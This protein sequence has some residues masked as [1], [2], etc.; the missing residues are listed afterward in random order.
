MFKFSGPQGRDWISSLVVF[1]VAL[2]LS[3][4]IALASGAPPATG[5][6]TAV[7]GGIVAGALAGAPLSVTGPAAGLTAIVFQ[8]VQ[9]Y[10]IAGI[11][12]ITFIAGVMQ[13]AMGAVRAGRFFTLIPTPVLEGVLSA[14]GL[15]IVLGQM[16]ILLG[17]SI[18]TS[19][20]RS[21]LGIPES[22]VNAF[23]GSFGIMPV[24]LCG[25]IALAIQVI[26]PR[27]AKHRLKII[28]GALPAVILVTL[29]SLLWE[30]PRVELA[31]F[32]TVI[33]NAVG[34]FFSFGWMSSLG[35]YLMPAV[36]LA[37]VASAESMLTARAV[38]ILIQNRPGFR[39]CNLNRELVAQGAANLTSGMIGG[40]PMTGVM[41]RSATNVNA[42]GQTRWSTILHGLWI[43]VL[44]MVAPG[45][46]MQI[47][48]TALAAVLILVG[49]K[50]INL[51]HFVHVLRTHKL[52]GAA[53]FATTAAVFVTDLLKGL[54]IGIVVYMILNYEKVIRAMKRTSPQ[55]SREGA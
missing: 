45:L 52:D 21:A 35:T 31:P 44:V 17:S 47:P 7:A 34:E 54:V 16:H 55:P 3:L 37:I 11:A 1:I 18:P 43:A 4:G 48:L 39:P 29:I 40:L 20:I 26:W 13:I 53:W 12:I 38:D 27:F 14:I 23:G 33:A 8:L 50:L 41:V 25:L 30:M 42:G 24:F 10:G 49:V 36:G 51:P 2:P 28:P 22:L 32:D 15:I 19:P 5:L 46:L 9:Q 6:I